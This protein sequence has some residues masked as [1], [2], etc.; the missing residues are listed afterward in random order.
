LGAGGTVN[1]FDRPGLLRLR[2]LHDCHFEPAL[3]ADTAWD[4]LLEQRATE[5]E[6]RRVAIFSLRI[7]T[8]APPTKTLR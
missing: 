8:T 5:Y 2:R 4:I 1:A 3:L 6:R 7:T